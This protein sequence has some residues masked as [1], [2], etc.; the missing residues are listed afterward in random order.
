MTG[1]EA[2]ATIH[3][4]RLVECTRVE[5]EGEIRRALQDAAARWIDQAQ[6]PYAVIA[7]QEVRRLDEVHGFNR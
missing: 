1:K 7:L 6:D 4:A 2:V 5:Y 3:Q